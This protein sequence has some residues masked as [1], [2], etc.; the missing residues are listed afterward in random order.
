MPSIAGEGSACVVHWLLCS[1]RLTTSAMAKTERKESWNEMSN[2]ARGSFKQDQQGRGGQGREQLILT[3][4][5]HGQEKDLE[6]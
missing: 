5:P 2:S 1:L 4:Q 3:S 6:S